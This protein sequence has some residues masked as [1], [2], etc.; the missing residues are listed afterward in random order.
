MTSEHTALLEHAA[1]GGRISPAEALELY[2]FAPLHAL[3][4]AA[5]HARRARFGDQ[6]HLATYLIDRN[7]NYTNVCTTAC[8]F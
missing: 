8:K 7:I 6:A 5:D 4:Q 2:R 1:H 3:G